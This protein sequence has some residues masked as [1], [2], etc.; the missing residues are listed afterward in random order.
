MQ[1]AKPPERSRQ[2]EE[3]KENSYIS[4]RE[5]VNEHK[6][7]SLDG[8]DFNPG[9]RF[10]LAFS[11]LA[12]LVIMLALDGTSVSVALPVSLSIRTPSLQAP[13]ADLE[14]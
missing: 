12:I 10:Y 6:A 8:N 2:E 13:E 1:E 11:S 14:L 7:E 5:Q 3:L 9:T 4:D